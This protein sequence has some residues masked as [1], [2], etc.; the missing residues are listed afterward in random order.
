MD[1]VRVGR[2]YI[3]L[4]SRRGLDC[5][6]LAASFVLHLANIAWTLPSLYSILVLDVLR[7]RGTRF[8]REQA[9][10]QRTLKRVYGHGCLN[11]SDPLVEEAGKTAI[12]VVSKSNFEAGPCELLSMRL[13][14]TTRKLVRYS[15]RDAP[16]GPRIPA[17]FQYGL[18]IMVRRALVLI[19][20]NLPIQIPTAISVSPCIFGYPLSLVCLLCFFRALQFLPTCPPM[21][22]GPSL[23]QIWLVSCDEKTVL[24]FPIGFGDSLHV[25][26]RAIPCILDEDPDVRSR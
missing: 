11:S 6:R 23:S 24:V 25:S 12:W 18:T 5:I 17:P 9:C 19:L 14:V 3:E 13:R 4:G 15:R 26:H 2:F 1:I 7:D 22:S 16:P 21:S 10:G 20:M 8:H